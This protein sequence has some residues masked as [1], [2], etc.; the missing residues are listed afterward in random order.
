MTPPAPL[1]ALEPDLPARSSTC[2]IAVIAKA[3]R[4]GHVKTRLQAILHPD[5]AAA[6]GAA[7]LRDTL[8]NLA[9]AARQVPIAP[10][11]AYAP[12]GQE[13]RFDG[14]LPPGTAL[15]LADGTHG[16]APG[17]H[18]FGRVLLDTTRALLAQGYAAACVLGA[19][20]P[21][22][23]TA[24]LVRCAEALLSGRADA[25]LGAA[26]D[27]GYYILGLTEP[28]AT[29][30]ADISWSTGIVAAQTRERLAHLRLEELDAWYDVDDPASLTRLVQDLTTPGGSTP[31]QATHTAGLVE[32][33][34]LSERLSQFAA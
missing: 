9:E 21:T 23:P 14:M 5:E 4:P 30:Y 26:E 2:A 25:V 24:S 11:V 16:D 7:F 19:D 22:L 15:L 13:A 27:G 28:H 1:P 12:A 17:V 20:S 3:P 10:V 18:G 32:R 29:P 6:M 8:D 33:L 34:R 31:Y